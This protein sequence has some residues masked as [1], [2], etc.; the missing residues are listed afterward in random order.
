M[1]QATLCLLRRDDEVLL[2]LKKRGFGK[3]HIVGIGGT[4]EAGETPE[5][6]VVREV[7]EEIGVV[8]AARDLLTVAHIAFWFPHRPSWHMQVVVFV[9]HQWLGEPGESAEIRPFWFPVAALPT[10]RMWDDSRLWLPRVL[11][12]ERLRASFT[13]APDNTTVNH[14]TIDPL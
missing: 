8:V 6:T 1:K 4:L 7:E 14:Y 9:A 11:T 10:E 2:G 3:G 12:G 13:Y 5:Q